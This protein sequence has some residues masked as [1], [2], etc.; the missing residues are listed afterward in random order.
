MYVIEI[1]ERDLRQIKLLNGYS[2]GEISMN[3]SW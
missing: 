1:S 2:N 3:A